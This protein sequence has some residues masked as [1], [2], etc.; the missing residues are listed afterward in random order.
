M[1]VFFL[2]VH[3]VYYLALQ[4]FSLLNGQTARAVFGRSWVRFLY[5]GLETG[6]G[7]R[8]SKALESFLARKAIFRSSVSK[9]LEYVNK[10]AL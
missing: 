10:T 7:A 6:P 4:E 2:T 9:N 8:F 5:S 1:N 3:L